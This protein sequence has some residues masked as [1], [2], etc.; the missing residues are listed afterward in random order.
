MN[1]LRRLAKGIQDIGVKIMSMNAVFLSEE[2]VVRVTNRKYVTVKRED[3]KGNFDLIVDIN[4]AEV[5]E[6]K[7]QDL[8][9]ML[10]TM[11]PNMDPEMSKLILADIAE[12]KRM[13]ALAEKIRTHQPQPD[14]FAEEMKQL[15]LEK[16]RAQIQAL[17]AD[18]EYKM[19]L[20]KKAAAEGD[21]ANL[22]FVEEQSGT[23]HARKLESQS[24]QAR[25]N[26]DLE[27]T[28]A[29]L[30]PKKAEESVPDVEAA[31]G[32]NAMTDAKQAALMGY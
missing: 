10:Q 18:A 26:Q 8:G 25:A 21:L 22:D 7:A 20:A 1:I 30:K 17:Q 32:Y 5:D 23:K 19:A 11:G 24:A 29:L 3:L 14:P 4:T 12:L 31:V 27:V 15:E 28:K 9:F 16:A 13:P 2:E 6:A